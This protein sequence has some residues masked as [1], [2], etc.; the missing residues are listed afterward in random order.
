MHGGEGAAD[1]KENSVATDTPV[2]STPL[3]WEFYPEYLII[4]KEP[5]LVPKWIEEAVSMKEQYA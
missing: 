3:F 1:L 4:Y 2:L 5:L